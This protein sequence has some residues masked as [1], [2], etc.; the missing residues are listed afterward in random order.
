MFLHTISS[1]H[2]FICQ[3]ALGYPVGSFSIK[4]NLVIS[5]HLGSK[6]CAT[7]C[8]S[9]LMVIK[10]KVNNKLKNPHESIHNDS[11]LSQKLSETGRLNLGTSLVYP[12]SLAGPVVWVCI[13][14]CYSYFIFFTS[15]IVT[16]RLGL[17]KSYL[18]DSL[19]F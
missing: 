12:S 9:W 13:C 17:L 7:T 5:L 19:C 3:C 18:M 2:N 1:V 11:R 10:S 8:P 6:Y 16:L 15:F 4:S 14:S